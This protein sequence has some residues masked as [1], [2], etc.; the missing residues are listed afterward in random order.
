MDIHVADERE[1]AELRDLWCRTFGDKADYVD[2]IYEILDARGYVL[3]ESGHVR[4]C[5]TLFEAG[6]YN[7]KKVWISYAICT[8]EKYRGHG[9]ASELTKHVRDLILEKGEISMLCPANATL[10]SFYNKLGYK[11][12]FYSEMG[13]VKKDEDISVRIEPLDLEKYCS[14]R[15]EFL[16]NVPHVSL[17]DKLLE[18][19]VHDSSSNQPMLLVNGGDAI[20]MIECSDENDLSLVEIVVNPGLLAYSAE[21]AHQIAEGLATT[22]DAED[23]CFYTTSNLM[24]NENVQG[25]IAGDDSL[26]AK[27]LLLP[28]FG[29]PLQ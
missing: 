24:S 10:V 17:S 1:Y 2:K 8:E 12:H 4:S 14:Y 20:A 7:N 13:V 9:F 11:S 18:F 27:D 22:L 26:I 3:V 29:F 5:L 16:T 23:A 15:E 6:S 28:Y 25:M 21:I 19:A